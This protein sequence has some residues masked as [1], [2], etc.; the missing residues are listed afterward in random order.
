MRLH[1]V[2]KIIFVKERCSK[3]MCK[4]SGVFNYAGEIVGEV[5]M[6]LSVDCDGSLI[7]GRFPVW[8][9]FERSVIICMDF[10]VYF[11]EYLFGGTMEWVILK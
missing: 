4:G 8:N 10:V 5:A 3:K 11:I 7:H 1:D 6:C 2:S 9:I